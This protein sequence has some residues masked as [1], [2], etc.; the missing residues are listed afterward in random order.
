MCVCI[1]CL[2]VSACACGLCECVLCVRV[3]A[4]VHLCGCVL[5]VCVCWCVHASVCTRACSCAHTG[6][7]Q[8]GRPGSSRLFPA[9]REVT[10]GA[11]AAA[12]DHVLSP[13]APAPGH[14]AQ[15]QAQPGDSVRAAGW[16]RPEPPQVASTNGWMWDPGRGQ[17]APY[18][19]AHPPRFLWPTPATGGRPP[20]VTRVSSTGGR[21]A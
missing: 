12:Q 1:L 3:C 14:V 4:C 11:V 13:V 5:H 10:G 8:D 2:R 15:P 18:G 16:V 6:K 21:G 19:T 17:D 7:M 20:R 9:F